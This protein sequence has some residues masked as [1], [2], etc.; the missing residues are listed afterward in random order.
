MSDALSYRLQRLSAALLAPLVII[1]L[2]TILFAIHGGLSADEILQRTR[3]NLMWPALY[4][5]FV[6]AAAVHAPLGLRNILREW[7]RARHAAID[8]FVLLFALVLLG[9]GLRAVVA[10]S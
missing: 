9:L 2:I 3:S 4:T 6:I 7:T 5:V 10:I 1:H 8:I